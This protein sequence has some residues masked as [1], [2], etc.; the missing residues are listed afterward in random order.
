LSTSATAASLSSARA[1]FCAMSSAALAVSSAS[2]AVFRAA[3]A[4]SRRCVGSTP[5]EL[6]LSTRRN[7]FSV[8]SVACSAR[9]Q[10]MRA[11]RTSSSRAPL[12]ALSRCAAAAPRAAS[13]W[14]SL[15]L[16][17]GLSIVATRSPRVTV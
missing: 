14:T 8:S 1:P 4:S 16:S 15:A 7:V 5:S 3:S 10:A 11:A 9:S 17:S 13:A 12:H 2:R 6:S